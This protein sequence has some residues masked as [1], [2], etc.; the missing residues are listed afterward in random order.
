ML[1]AANSPLE[2]VMNG[3]Q[4]PHLLDF[5]AMFAGRT[6]TDDI[7]HAPL[8]MA[9]KANRIGATKASLTRMFLLVQSQ[10]HDRV[11]GHDS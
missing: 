10:V 2:L 9:F 3:W 5:H 8:L 4:L 11:E 1:P 7:A 6:R